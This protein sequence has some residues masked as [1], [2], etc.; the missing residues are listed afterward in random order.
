[1]KITIYALIALGILAA[2]V[3]IFVLGLG[4]WPILWVAHGYK[5]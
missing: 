2:A 1:M 4:L 3:V 5:R